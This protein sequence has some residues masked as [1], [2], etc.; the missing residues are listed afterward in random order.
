MS[1]H[2]WKIQEELVELLYHGVFNK[3]TNSPVTKEKLIEVVEK[4]DEL[5]EERIYEYN[6]RYDA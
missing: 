6:H 5:I 4:I 2:I 3:E 1:K